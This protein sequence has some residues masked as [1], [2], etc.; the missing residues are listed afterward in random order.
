M[1][2]QRI[3]KDMVIRAAFELARIGG[4]ENVTLKDIASMLGCSVQPVYSYCRSMDGLRSEVCRIA[5]DFVREYVAARTDKTDPFRSTGRAYVRLAGEEGNILR[6]FLFRR[7]E[8]ISGL[9]ALYASETDPRLPAAIAS[10]LG[11]REET[12]RRLHLNML[13]YTLG[14]CSIFSVTAPGLPLEEIYR[15]QDAAF[16]AFL[17]A[18][19]EKEK[20]E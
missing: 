5:G 14:L 20:H 15:Q 11:L 10:Q 6:M 3:N 18:A 9:G 7:R 8:N 13:V 17:R 2:R 12:A 1:P 19:R 4:L 16:D